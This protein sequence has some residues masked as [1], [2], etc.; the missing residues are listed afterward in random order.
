MQPLATTIGPVILFL[1]TSSEVLSNGPAILII[2][3]A[4]SFLALLFSVADLVLL[5]EDN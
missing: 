4:P 2:F 5:D 3:V 1:A